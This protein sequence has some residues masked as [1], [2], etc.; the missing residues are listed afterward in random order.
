[1]RAG[2]R[3]LGRPHRAEGAALGAAYPA[4]LAPGVWRDLDEVTAAA[5]FDRTFG[6]AMSVERRDELYGGWLQA[7]E[8]AKGWASDG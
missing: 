6:P 2:V 5:T 1:M 3:P 8:R 4:G 7:V